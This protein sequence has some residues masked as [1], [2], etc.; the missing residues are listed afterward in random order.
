MIK[1]LMDKQPRAQKKKQFTEEELIKAEYENLWFVYSQSPIPTCTLSKEGIV[2]D[3]NKA[4]KDLTEYSHR[5]LPDIVTWM[6]RLYPDEDYRN[7]AIK[8]SRKS[9]HRE[10]SVDQG[11]WRIT[12]KSGEYRDVHIIVYDIF[13]EGR[14]TDMQIVQ[15]VGTTERAKADKILRLTQFAM[16]KAS[17]AM[18][19]SDKD[20]NIINVNIQA[21]KSLGY[22]RE[23]LLNMSIADINPLFPGSKWAKHWK[24]IQKRKSI[25]FESQHRKKSGKI[26]P[27]EINANYLE[28]GGVGY[29]FGYATDITERKKIE[30]EKKK[31]TQNLEKEVGKRTKE[32]QEKLEQLEQFEKFA[33]GR[34]IKMIELKKRIT[35][36]ERQLHRYQQR[37]K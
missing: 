16:D 10:T 31:Y 18:F 24:E 26:F 23:E 17:V 28:I 11:V 34:E 3:Y 5:E 29:N 6:K 2:Q 32:L 21:C 8:A 22:S 14:P 1:K 30:E 27:V 33:V 4:M 19:W 36:L 35:E 7:K 15:F 13:H 25:I 12:R 9:R 20:A 37:K